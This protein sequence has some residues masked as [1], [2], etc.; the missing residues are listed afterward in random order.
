[1]SDYNRCIGTDYSDPVLYSTNNPHNEPTG[2]YTG[3]CGKCGSKDLWDSGGA[4]LSYGCKT[5]GAFFNFD[6]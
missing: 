1:M 5:C 6:S 2:H 3:R 4:T